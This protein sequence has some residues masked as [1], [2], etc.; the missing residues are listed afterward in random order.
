MKPDQRREDFKTFMN[1]KYRGNADAT[2]IINELVKANEYVFNNQED[3][4]IT[5][6]G[7]VKRR[8]LIKRK[9]IKKRK[10]MKHIKKRKTMKHIK[11]RKTMKYLIKKKK[12]MK[13][14]T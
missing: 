1:E 12:T 3:K 6:G 7:R 5:F 9:T 8:K 14:I 10:T 13:Y 11:K 4:E 2:N